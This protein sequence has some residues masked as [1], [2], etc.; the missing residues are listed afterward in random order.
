[1]IKEARGFGSTID[2]ARENAI[3]NLNPGPEDDLQFEVIATEKK[4]VLG[5][6]GG[7]RAEVRVYVEL[8]DERPLPTRKQSKPAA[9]LEKSKPAE[10]KANGKAEKPVKPIAKAPAAKAPATEKPPVSSNPDSGYGELVEV[11]ALPADSRARG[12][13]SYLNGVL[14]H[15]GCQNVSVKVAEKEN[16]ALIVLEGDGLGVVIGRRGEVL[17]SI[18]YL[19]SLSAGSGNGYYKVTLNI[20]NYREKREQTLQALATRVCEQVLATNKNRSLDPMNPYERRIIHT[21]V[22]EIAG[23]VSGSFGEGSNRRVVIA[24]EG[25]DLRPPRNDDRR[26]SR[27]DYGRGRSGGYGRDHDRN[28][29]RDNRRPNN[30]AAPSPN[31]EPKKDSDVP[32]YGK[33]N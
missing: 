17:D 23:V 19:T 14:A 12:A 2:E 10:N 4:K 18:Q 1:M 3:A 26:G 24:P 22:Q 5:L 21:T 9:K 13:I 31:R 16:G 15:L 33:I 29:D 11:E 6:F 20:G 30:N 25:G 8:P 28:R 32:L 27:G 7:N